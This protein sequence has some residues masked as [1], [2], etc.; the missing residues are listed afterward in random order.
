MY[1]GEWDELYRAN[2]HMSRWP[3]TDLVT[4]VMRYARPDNGFRR[5]LELGCG[6]GANIPFF[7]DLGVD[8]YAIEGSPTAVASIHERFP[9]LR[10]KVVIG[11]YTRKIPFSG[12][13][14]LVVDRSSLTCN[15]TESIAHCVGLLGSVLRERGRFIAV[16][17]FSLQHSEYPFGQD[18]GDRYTRKNFSRGGFAG[19][20]DVHF[21]DREHL[22][23]FFEEYR[24]LSLQHKIVAEEC[25]DNET[26]Q[27][28]TWNVVAERD[29]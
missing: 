10:E 24:V 4:L 7:A 3:W 14:D 29:S 21:F 12:P 23:S 27:I 17:W 9:P 18:V 28:A 22:L 16:D 8:Y 26:R 5:V 13:F 19:A 15:R 25:P 20:G 11:D 1:C 2:R 6:V